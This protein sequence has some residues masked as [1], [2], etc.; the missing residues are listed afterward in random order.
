MFI[1]RGRNDCSA[2]PGIPVPLCPESGFRRGPYRGANFPG[3]GVLDQA[4][5]P[6]S[7][8]VDLPAA[9]PA[10][11]VPEVA[12]E[13]L[14]TTDLLRGHIPDDAGVPQAGKMFTQGP[15]ADLQGLAEDLAAGPDV[16]L[17]LTAEFRVVVVV[18]EQQFQQGLFREGKAPAIVQPIGRLVES[19]DESRLWSVQGTARL[20]VPSPKGGSWLSG[21]CDSHF[22]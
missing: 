10:A 7:F 8:T 20:R 4:Q 17:A 19:L 11:G 16:A 21:Q 1:Y 9:P 3:L 22:S 2:L 18:G 12:V 6:E 13:F 5:A 14:E 15:V